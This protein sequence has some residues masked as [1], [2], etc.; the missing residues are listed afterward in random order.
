MA[1]IKRTLSLQEGIQII[2]FNWQYVYLNDI[3]VLQSG[4]QEGSLIG[5]KMTAI[6]S[7]IADA[8]LFDILQQ[9]M[10]DR[11]PHRFENH[12][13]YPNGS[14][15]WFD[16]RVQP[17]EEGICIFSVDIT[18]RKENE[19]NLRKANGLYA[20]LTHISQKIVTA[21]D[22][23]ELFRDCCSFALRFADFNMAWIGLFD[24]GLKTLT[25]VD[26]SGIPEKEL[27]LFYEALKNPNEQLDYIVRSGKY[28]ISTDIQSDPGLK[29]WQQYAFKHSIQSCILLPIRKSGQIIGLFSL[30]SGES[31]FTES[32]IELLQQVTNDI[33]QALDIFEQVK[34]Q[35]QIQQLLLHNE[36]QFRHTLDHMI[37]GAQIHDFNWRYTYVND[38]L[39]KYSTYT[40]EELLG[41]SLLEKYPGIEQTALFATLSRCMEERVSEKIE[42][43]FVFPN[44]SNANFELS[45]QPV[46]EG[47]FILSVDRSEQLKANE[48]LMKANRLYAFNS[49]I[50]QAIVHI[51]DQQKLMDNSCLIAIDIGKF[52]LAWI[53]TIEDKRLKRVS[54]AGTTEAIAAAA[55]YDGLVVEDLIFHETPTG[56]VFRTGRY[57]VSNDIMNDPAVAKWKPGLLTCGLQSSISLPIKKFGNTVGVFELHAGTKD[58]FD[59]EEIA[60]L[61]EATDDISFAVENFEKE[62]I[63]KATEELVA[64]NEKRF[65]ILIEKSADIKTLAT[66]EGKI[67]YGS[68]SLTK[69]MGYQVEELLHTSL[70]DLVHPDDLPEFVMAR[71]K[72]LDIPGASFNFQQRRMHKDGRWLWFEGSVT[73]ML[74]EPGIN[75]MVSNFRDIT[76]KKISEQQREFDTR[77]L[78]ALINNTHDL[79]WSIDRDYK[80]ITS[81]RPFDQITAKIHGK[82]LEKG[83]CV[84]KGVEK[85][86]QKRFISFYEKAFSG[87]IFSI[88][89]HNTKPME[90][91]SEISFYPIE[92]EE[93]IIG[94]ACHSRNITERIKSEHLLRKS[95]IFNR[96]ILDSLSAHIAVINKKGDIIAVNDSWRR[97]ARKNGDIQLKSTI[98]G[99]NYFMAC[100]LSIDQGDKDAVNVLA[101]IKKV[102]KGTL[103]DFYYEYPCHS[104]TEQRWFSMLVRKF[105]ND[106][107]LIVISH[108]DITARKIVE[109][110]LLLNNATLQKTNDELDRFVYSVSHDLR[111]PLTSILGLVNLIEMES[112]EP[113]TLSHIT[114]IR[115]SIIRL[116]NFIK[117]ILNYSRNNRTDVESEFI[118]VYNTVNDIVVLLRGAKEYDDIAFEIDIIEEFPF[119][120]DKHRFITIIENLISNAIKYHK[121]Q[122]KGRF[123]RISGTSRQDVLEL[124]IADNGTG[125]APGHHSKI[126]DMFYR[127]ANTINGSGLGLY[128]VKESIQKLGGTIVVTSK[129]GKGT[130]FTIHLKNLQL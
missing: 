77:N 111:A 82:S 21:K 3:A 80:L 55:P 84:L 126:F 109:N 61:L 59:E 117:N 9:S 96:G 95:E 78:N 75:A 19:T 112:K 31:Y 23:K 13:Q 6:F 67:I 86:R 102:M 43:E 100:E 26:Q 101:Q 108:Q 56:N 119:H 20:L 107:T 30:Y 87:E 127:I 98:E 37:E 62:R 53:N 113:D 70:L 63:Q 97:F 110:Q 8:P 93:K 66:R 122:E 39:V 51:K 60:L 34:K 52:K 69:I 90:F 73:N 18:E 17:C 120:S 41:Y 88:I 92:V 33:S 11:T 4:E 94:T 47:L 89:E 24:D 115:K 99:S 118:P 40:K 72:I 121:K 14:S 128:I 123:I 49:A 25:M 106:E 28:Y 116:D 79:L 71:N 68:P 83:D 16:L 38:A 76:H 22:Q 85:E 124:N 2:D 65:K 103:S 50:N 32:E 129:E 5:L 130:C 74:H 1:K 125:I 35:E 46:P 27:P 10:Q 36:Q 81:N 29:L 91:W 42:A 15:K 104:T 57:A 45:I 114:M 58:F 12:F 7:D 44:G 54:I 48:K 105:E 64:K